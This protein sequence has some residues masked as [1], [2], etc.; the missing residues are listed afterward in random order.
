MDG[1]GW[2][3]ESTPAAFNAPIGS[4]LKDPR[5]TSIPNSLVL[6][7]WITDFGEQDRMI[8]DGGLWIV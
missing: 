6:R 4:E 3:I 2:S 7:L 5:H 1:V 8:S